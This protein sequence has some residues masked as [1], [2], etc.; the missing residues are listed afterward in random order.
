M[1]YKPTYNWG[2]PSC[3][4]FHEKWL[5]Q[6]P[7]IWPIKP[8]STLGKL[9]MV[10]EFGNSPSVDWETTG[11]SESGTRIRNLEYLPNLPIN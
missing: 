2:A 11:D 10:S 7:I 4:M 5:C 9:G 1:V 6:W 8:V 3:S